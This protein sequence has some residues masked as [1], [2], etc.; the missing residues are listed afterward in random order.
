MEKLGKHPV[1]AK[2]SLRTRE[3]LTEELKAQK[4]HR[5]VLAGD[6][7]WSVEGLNRDEAARVRAAWRRELT[8]LR[9][10]GEL[11]DTVDSLA[12][13]GIERE[14]RARGWWE[15]RWPAVPGEALDPG[16]WPGSREGGYP[17]AV[18]LRLP[19]PLARKVY[20][21]C[22]HTSAR[23][24]TAL[25]EW[26]DHNPGLS[27]PR[28]LLTEDGAVQELTGPL[29]EYAELARQVTTV[30]EVWRGGLEHGIAAGTELRMRFAN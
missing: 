9:Q 17:K 1:T 15:R 2:V 11:L 4:E 18:P 24:I 12:V 5:A 14:L 8:R 30:G 7:R 21:A 27:L 10:G 16:R 25:R 23:A 26:R 13:H 22:W 29:R 6:E 3:R 28:W 19:Q 20:A